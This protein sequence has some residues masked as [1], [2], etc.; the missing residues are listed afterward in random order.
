MQLSAKQMQVLDQHA[1]DE[2]NRRIAA[3]VESRFPQAFAD[4]DDEQKALVIERMREAAAPFGLDRDDHVGTYIVLHL[5]Y[6]AG[7]ESQP[8]AASVLENTE[9]TPQAKIRAL[10]RRVGAAGIEL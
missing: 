9:L 2:G 6:G 1:R 8:W 7:F 3:Y 4:R 5:M 10:E